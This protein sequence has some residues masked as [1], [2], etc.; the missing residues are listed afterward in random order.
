[1]VNKCPECGGEIQA[2]LKVYLSEVVV[3]GNRII[4]Y[5]TDYPSATTR[6]L[7]LDGGP[8]DLDLYCV[9]DCALSLH[10]KAFDEDVRNP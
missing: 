5:R 6:E 10:D 2:T 3:A 4:K 7:I 8:E 1:M 9:N